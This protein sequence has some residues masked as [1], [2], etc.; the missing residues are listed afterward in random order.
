MKTTYS[1]RAN[2]TAA[3]VVEN[4]DITLE[5]GLTIEEAKIA[6]LEHQREGHHIAVWI[7]EE[8]APRIVRTVES[9]KS[10]VKFAVVR[11]DGWAV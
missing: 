6:S 7:E 10:G 3:D 1:I 8:K 5:T 9:N 11:I 2:K 4:N